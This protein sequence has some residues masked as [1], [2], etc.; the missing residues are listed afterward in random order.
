MPVNEGV[1]SHHRKE[2]LQEIRSTIPEC[3]DPVW[4][5][6]QLCAPLNEILEMGNYQEQTDLWL[7]VLYREQGVSWTENTVMQD[8]QKDHIPV[9]LIF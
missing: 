2:S 7:K 3:K 9:V 8:V 6:C 4:G 5:G 1:Q